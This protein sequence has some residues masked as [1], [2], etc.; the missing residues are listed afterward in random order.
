MPQ[1][2]ITQYSAPAYA[3]MLYGVESHDI[4]SFAAEEIIPI[5]YPVMRG[6]NPEKQVKKATT[7]AAAIGFALQDHTIIQ[8]GGGAVQYAA[9][10]TVSTLREG[11]FWVPTSDAVVAG[12]V[13]NLTVATGALTDA[14]VAAGIEAFT[15]ISVT[16]ETSTTGA[17]LALVSV[18]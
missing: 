17:G 10:E 12:A 8:N 18:K 2:S 13:A 4:S 16:F 1:T 6:T 11:W 14:A 9:K 5:A 3:G 15:K 7:G